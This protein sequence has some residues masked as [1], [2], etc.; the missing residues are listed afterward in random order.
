MIV[1]CL[2]QHIFLGTPLEMCYYVSYFEAMCLLLVLR[3]DPCLL[4]ALF[5]TR[6]NRTKILEF[7]REQWAVDRRAEW[8][9]WMVYLKV[10]MPHQ[11]ISSAVDDSSVHSLHG[12]APILR[13]LSEEVKT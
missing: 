12:R 8:S 4:F 3:L 13:K 5:K 6:S 7:L 11:Y 9:I 2:L 1:H 10:E